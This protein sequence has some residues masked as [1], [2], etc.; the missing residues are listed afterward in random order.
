MKTVDSVKSSGDYSLIK[1]KQYMLKFNNKNFLLPQNI[2]GKHNYM[3]AVTAIGACKELKVPINSQIKALSNFRGV[4]KRTDLVG[5][6]DGIKVFDDFAHHPTAI[7]SSINSIKETFIGKRLL[8]VFVPG[9][10]SMRLGVHDAQ[11]VP[12][13]KES[14]RALVLTKFKSLKRLIGNNIKINVIETEAQIREYLDRENN[15][16]VVLVLSNRNTKNILRYIKNE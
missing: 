1:K 14:D 15:F 7:K 11:L 2:I 4:S 16:D 8:T 9:S 13:L 3:N 6:V 12:S 10:N 5:E